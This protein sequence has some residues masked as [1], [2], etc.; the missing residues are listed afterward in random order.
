MKISKFESCY[1]VQEVEPPM[2]KATRNSY[3]SRAFNKNFRK[4]NLR[5]LVHLLL[6]PNLDEIEI[7]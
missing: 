4:D 7:N 5:L 6:L 1:Y 3:D 2:Y